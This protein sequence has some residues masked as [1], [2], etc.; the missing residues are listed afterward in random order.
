MDNISY[1]M[2]YNNLSFVFEQER[3]HWLLKTDKKKQLQ[4]KV[5][6]DL[7]TGQVDNL[8]SDIIVETE[9]MNQKNGMIR[10]INY[11]EPD[12]TKIMEIDCS[13][14]TYS[15]SV[16]GLMFERIISSNYPITVDDITSH[17][18]YKV[19]FNNCT[20]VIIPFGGFINSDEVFAGKWIK[21]NTAPTLLAMDSNGLYTIEKSMAFGNK[22]N[23]ATWYFPLV[24]FIQPL[25]LTKISSGVYETY[26]VDSDGYI[27]YPIYWFTCDETN[28]GPTTSFTNNTNQYIIIG[29]EPNTSKYNAKLY[30]GVVGNQDGTPTSEP[31]SSY[32]IRCYP[33][34][35][36]VFSNV[37][38][39]FNVKLLNKI[40]FVNKSTN[41]EHVITLTL[42]GND[43]MTMS[44][45]DAWKYVDTN[46]YEIEMDTFDGNCLELFNSPLISIFDI[47]FDESKPFAQTIT[48]TGFSGIR[49][50]AGNISSDVYD[51]YPHDLNNFDGLPEWIKN[52]DDGVPQHMAIYSIH[53]TPEY[54]L[55]DQMTRQCAGILLDPGKPKTSEGEGFEND[56]I[57]R[58]YV[59]SGDEITYKN[60]FNEECPK[61]PRTA[62]RICDIPTSAMQ[63]LGISDLSP[64]TVVD[65]EYVR[66]ETS[67]TNADKDRLYNV[68]GNRWVKPM[69]LDATG[70]PVRNIDGEDNDYVFRNLSSLKA[71]D[72]FDH[73]DFRLLTNLNPLVDPTNVEIASVIE[74]GLGYVVNDI[75]VIIV[76]GYAFNYTVTSIGADGIVKTAKLSPTSVIP[77]N[78][79]NF[80]MSEGTSGVT[81]TY[82]TSP[83]TGA[84]RGLKVKL[85][86]NDYNSLIMTDGEL[87]ED[88]F[89]LV[90]ENNGIWLYSY[91]INPY[92]SKHPKHGEWT[93]IIKI[94]D[95]EE[96][97]YAMS[98]GNVSTT[99]SFMN[100]I[101]PSLKTLPIAKTKDGEAPTSISA[102]VTPS[103]VNI[104]DKTKTPIS[105]DNDNSVD[106]CKL[107]CKGLLTMTATSKTDQAVIDALKTNNRLQYDSFIVWRWVSYTDPRNMKFEYGVIT[108]SFNNFISSDYTSALP[109]N[110]LRYKN[111]VHTNQA[112]TVVWEVDQV[113][114]MMWIYNP[115]SNIH[116]KYTIDDV[117]DLRIEKTKVTWQNID[118]R[119]KDDGT[120]CPIV[121]TQGKLIYNILTNNPNQ[122]VNNMTDQPIYQQ[123]EFTQFNDLSIGTP[124]SVITELHQ[125]IGNWQL[126]FPRVSNFSFTNISTEET[127]KPIHMLSVRNNNTSESAI[128]TNEFGNNI[129]TKTVIIDE[130]TNGI[131]L[132]IFDSST[133]TWKK[134]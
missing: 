10:N 59:L 29:N 55:Q 3:K 44:V 132:K 114:M 75:G 121:D 74:K 65:K 111:H 49:A 101:I 125:P 40:T 38:N 91:I 126:T 11:F 106:M 6:G 102:V 86:I 112:T 99:E 39:D 2:G 67:Y 8:G 116:E 87:Y 56:E 15:S 82:G 66:S 14:F 23:N 46:T 69:S 123:P 108:R 58:A 37:Q 1:Y 128:I 105:V 45:N 107:Y 33:E 64:T 73:N 26:P 12:M 81:L 122:C 94:S 25:P 41:A 51:R 42:T 89:A 119:F 120:Q 72:I 16:N 47:H 118:V 68:L 129:N 34:A 78:L 18:H 31:T 50:S 19:R 124:V 63:L 80:S 117:N 104:I 85:K 92:S 20:E 9:K 52:Q 77:V 7:Y 35:P 36:F 79:S 76:G 98:E 48:D 96:S 110:S 70:T 54:N 57:G 88:L 21:T 84:G 61:P 130:S 60:N 62:A 24:E 93:K 43:K 71:V 100:S 5:T 17:H 109:E 103:F 133:N 13:G 27:G 32:V 131:N 97:N 4:D 28:L 95:Y 30:T 115:L 90:S 83:L 22:V 53:N 113:G 134:I 127:I